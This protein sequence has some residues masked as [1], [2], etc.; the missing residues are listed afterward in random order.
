MKNILL[1][2][3]QYFV[4]LCFIALQIFCIVLLSKSSKTHEAFFSSAANE[5]TGKINK[6]Y[7]GI[8]DYLALKE[9]NKQL[10]EENARLKNLLLSNFQL[11][12]TSKITQIDSLVKDSLNRY[13][14]FTYLPAKVVGNSVTSNANF[15]MLERGTLQGVTKDMSVVSPAGIIGVVTDVSDNFSKVMSLLHKNTRVSAM[16]LKNSMS[17]DVEWD[18]KNAQFVTMKK[19]SKTAEAKIGD[20][21]VTSNY[22]ANYPAKL[23]VGTVV[24]IT[25]Q[26]ANS[27]NNLKIKTT[28][29]FFSLQYAYIIKNTYWAEQQ[30]L[31]QKKEPKN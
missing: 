12:D 5:V 24:E 26:E 2:I 19:V 29:N 7:Y 16:L 21:V 18:G 17:G 27:Y 14:K 1:F 22:S 3:Q 25:P 4:F 20:T 30:S 6:R 31:Q 13:R 11:P 9:N 15:I 8:K 23:M 10:V 28:V